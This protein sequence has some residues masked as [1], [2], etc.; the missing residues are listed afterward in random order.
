MYM[1]IDFPLVAREHND[2]IYPV[3]SYYIARV[4][5]RREEEEVADPLLHA[6]LLGGRHGD[7][8]RV[9]LHRRS[10]AAQ[11]SHH[12]PHLSRHRGL[13]RV[14]RRRRLCCKSSRRSAEGAGGAVLLGGDLDHGPSPH[15]LLPHRRSL[16][17]CGGD[18]RLDQLGPVSLLVSFLF[19]SSKDFRFRYGYEALIVDHMQAER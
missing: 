6:H 8:V 5:S 4:L 9:L 2:G 13:H 18:A 12:S 19:S 1:P 17:E 10:H 14:S 7:G 15:H 11:L 16:H 3:L